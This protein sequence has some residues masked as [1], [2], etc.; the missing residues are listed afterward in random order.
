VWSLCDCA[1]THPEYLVRPEQLPR[2]R[3]RHVGLADV[4]TV[5]AKGKGDI[6]TV[7]DDEWH[8]CLRT[9]WLQLLPELCSAHAT[10]HRGQSSWPAAS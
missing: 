10:P 6:N 9:Y 5:R 1:T 2:E 8:P 4:H 7:V 3:R